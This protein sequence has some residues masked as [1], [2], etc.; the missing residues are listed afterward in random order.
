MT[1][2][3]KVLIIED[4]VGSKIAEALR[5]GGFATIEN[6]NFVDTSA[7]SQ[8]S[9]PYCVRLEES[10]QLTGMNAPKVL[11]PHHQIHAGR[12]PRRW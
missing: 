2:E 6:S 4:T 11:P 10:R 8:L 3:M 1:A 12:K 7:P 9:N 5:R